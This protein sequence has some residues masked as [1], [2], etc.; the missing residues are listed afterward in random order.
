[1]STAKWQNIAGSKKIF[2][3]AHFCLLLLLT[4]IWAVFYCLVKGVFSSRMQIFSH[5]AC[6]LE[7]ELQTPEKLMKSTCNII[8]PFVYLRFH[9]FCD[10]ATPLKKINLIHLK[11]SH[12]CNHFLH[13]AI[14]LLIKFEYSEKATKFCEIFTFCLY[15]VHTDKSKFKILQN[16]IAFSEYMNFT[17]QKHCKYSLIPAPLSDIV[18]RFR[19]NLPKKANM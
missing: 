17:F 9:N 8:N 13:L 10:S 4:V 16:F 12:S 1:M 14:I 6:I 18:L 2:R 15:I 5:S 19:Q 7:T 3:T 11:K